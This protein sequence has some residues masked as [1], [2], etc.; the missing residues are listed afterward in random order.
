[1]KLNDII[2]LA[3][4]GYKPGEVKELTE[5][6]YTPA[7]L[8]D[9]AKAGYKPA[10]A[11]ELLALADTETDGAEESAEIQQKDAAQPEPEKAEK[12]PA[13]DTSGTEDRYN[14]MQQQIDSL[15]NQL[16]A[17]QKEN[18]QKDVSGGQKDP[19]EILNEITRK[20]M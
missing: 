11:K 3:M 20:F 14:E 10:E 2:S 16:S 19:Q 1:M 6:G 9:L 5:A 15:K 7:Q 13:A 17:A 12:E 4:S 8:K 18:T